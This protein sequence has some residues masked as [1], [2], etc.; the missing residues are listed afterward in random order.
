VTAIWRPTLLPQLAAAVVAELVAAQDDRFLPGLR[1]GVE[2][3]DPPRLEGVVLQ[4]EVGHQRG[5]ADH[6]TGPQQHVDKRLAWSRR[7]G[8]GHLG[9]AHSLGLA[10]GF[11]QRRYDRRAFIFGQRFGAGRNATLLR[12]LAGR[13]SRNVTRLGR[14]GWR[15]GRRRQGSD[16]K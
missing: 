10:A 3:V 11:N 16:E 15:I 2:E 14:P 12:P 9:L 6:E 5:V 1:L 4:V 7:G 8:P 13:D